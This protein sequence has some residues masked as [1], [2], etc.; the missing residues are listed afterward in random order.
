MDN[1]KK[2]TLLEINRGRKMKISNEG[3]KREKFHLKKRLYTIT[4]NK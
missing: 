2:T 3:I 1:A 4:M